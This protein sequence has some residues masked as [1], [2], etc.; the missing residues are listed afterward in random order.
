MPPYLG[1]LRSYW[2]IGTT[3]IHETVGDFWFAVLSILSIVG[4]LLV[5][6]I[7][8]GVAKKFEYH[9]VAVI[10]M[11]IVTLVAIAFAL[12][13]MFT[14]WTLST[15]TQAG[16]GLIPPVGWAGVGVVIA[17]VGGSC[18]IAWAIDTSKA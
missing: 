18:L 9:Y 3:M 5:F 11:I 12:A 10:I 13:F 15:E 8:F 14:Q 4:P 1:S 17:W 7:A 6:S 2:E 16:S